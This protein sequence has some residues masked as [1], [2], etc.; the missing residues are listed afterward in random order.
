M[1]GMFLG[2]QISELV[3]SKRNQ[4]YERHSCCQAEDHSMLLDVPIDK[5]SNDVACCL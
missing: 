4:L 5:E 2:D 3:C 1:L